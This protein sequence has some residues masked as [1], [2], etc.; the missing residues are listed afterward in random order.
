MRMP[1]LHENEILSCKGIPYKCPL[2]NHQ[3]EEEILVGKL[4]GEELTEGEFKVKKV[5]KVIKE[6]PRKLLEIRRARTTEIV[7]G[8]YNSILEEFKF[9]TE[10][11]TDFVGGYIPT[12]DTQL[13]VMRD[14]SIC[15]KFYEKPVSS[16]FVIMERSA[17]ADNLK[18]SSLSQEIIRRL[19]NTLETITK[20]PR[21]T[22]CDA[23][24]YIGRGEVLEILDKFEEKLS[25]S[26]YPIHKRQE[27]F[28]AGLTGYKRKLERT[29]GE[30]D[31]LKH[32]LGAPGLE[33]RRIGKILDK[34]GWFNK[35]SKGDTKVA[36][37]RQSG[38]QSMNQGNQ[39]GKV[40]AVLFVP[41]TP[42]GELIKRVRAKEKEIA[43]V[44]GDKIKVVERAGTPVERILVSKDPWEKERCKDSSCSYCKE[45]DRSICSSKN[46]VYKH[47]CLACKGKGTPAVYWGQTSRTLAE[48]G[49]EHDGELKNLSEGSHAYQHLKE[50]HQDTLEKVEM[51]DLR[52]LFSWKIHK[53]CQT[54]FQRRLLE[55][56]KIKQSKRNPKEINM[57]LKE[58][59]A[60]YA[61][62]SLAVKGVDETE[63]VEV[64]PPQ[65]RE[66]MPAKP[67]PEPRRTG[68][69]WTIQE[70]EDAA[71]KDK[72]SN[73]TPEDNKNIRL[74]K[75]AGPLGSGKPGSTQPE[76]APPLLGYLPT[77]GLLTL[78]GESGSSSP[79]EQLPPNETPPNRGE[80]GD[81][82]RIDSNNKLMPR[83]HD[84]EISSC[85]G[86]PYKCPLTNHQAEN[87]NTK[88]ETIPSFSS[89]PVKMPGVARKTD[90][91]K[92]LSES[93]KKRMM[94]L[95][96]PVKRKKN[97]Q[98]V[99]EKRR[100]NLRLKI[101]NEPGQTKMDRWMMRADDDDDDGTSETDTRKSG[102]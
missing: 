40:L 33:D 75:D 50:Y 86:I 21:R 99:G 49:P 56:V 94:T 28:K 77:P 43:K 55:A 38:G 96:P 74:S 72:V 7:R 88:E 78:G 48:R 63:E 51:E 14:G 52:R 69:L 100:D 59:W 8:V 101:A 19:S 87:D 42:G 66:L 97:N 4:P 64:T 80:E 34:D 12:L 39:G 58:E 82:S 10:L 5:K 22:V 91:V 47:V 53:K 13:K 44:T 67:Y 102:I 35:E 36:G 65:V 26:G 20:V 32:V 27:I 71:T 90:M 45:E 81:E 92:I 62:P 85:K 61:L 95:T 11:E 98:G 6:I 76:E 18:Q 15:Y 2:T 93:K 37:D 17:L 46:V 84:D 73:N 60:G 89:P 70:I 3:A 83:L 25:L 9:T 41:R 24:R 79:R 23:D 31:G 1:G 29:L 54:A 30:N 68:K 57:N 16:K